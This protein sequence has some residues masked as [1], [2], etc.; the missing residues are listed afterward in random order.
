MEI[1]LK[2]QSDMSA[3]DTGGGTR[4][5]TVVIEIDSTMHPRQQR[6]QAIYETAG[7]CLGFVLDHEQLE[8]FTEKLMDTLD[9]LEPIGNGE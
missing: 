9:Q 5:V 4:E 2:K 3:F 7:A 8:D 6:Q 1:I